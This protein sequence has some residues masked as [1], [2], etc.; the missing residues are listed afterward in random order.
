MS[1]LLA[2]Y[3]LLLT[4]IGMK[5]S[6]SILLCSLVLL[7]SLVS[8]SKVNDKNVNLYDID[9]TLYPPDIMPN[10]KKLAWLTDSEVYLKGGHHIGFLRLV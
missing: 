9:G 2:V 8:S 4:P 10:S 6:I 3:R 5:F 7:H 1:V